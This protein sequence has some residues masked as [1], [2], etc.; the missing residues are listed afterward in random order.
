MI[1]KT[2]HA[3]PDGS[4]YE[5]DPAVKQY[6]EDTYITPGKVKITL[7]TVDLTV[8]VTIEYANDAAKLEWVK[9][10]IVRGF[11]AARRAFYTA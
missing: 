1:S 3:R 5:M 8:T 6:I 7:L 4:F 10:P 2:V 9:D 11:L